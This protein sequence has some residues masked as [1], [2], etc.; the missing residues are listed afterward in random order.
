MLD[1]GIVSVL[2][3]GVGRVG[4]DGAERR[5]EVQQPR[6]RRQPRVLHNST[7]KLKSGFELCLQGDTSG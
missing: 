6:R 4:H 1:F 2:H 7:G 3:D 5:Q